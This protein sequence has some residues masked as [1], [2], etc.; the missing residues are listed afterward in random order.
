MRLREILGIKIGDIITVVGAGGKTT[1]MFT[2]G[3]ELRKDNKVLITTTTRIYMPE[4]HQFDFVEINPNGF[5][6]EVSKKG[7]YIYGESLDDENKIKGLKLE[8]LEKQ[9]HKFD[10]VLIEGD[11]SK[12]KP[13]KGWRENEPVISI[14]TTKTI[15][16]LSIEVI[17]K[18]INE[19]NVHR[20]DRFLDI[21]NSN[22][23][24]I[25]NL[26]KVISLIFHEKGLFKDSKGEKILFINKVE[27][28]T[29]KLIAEKLKEKIREV[30]NGYLNRIIYGSLRGNNYD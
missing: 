27:S 20:V 22:M 12:K 8:C 10:Y 7:I 16:V 28:H 30:S 19:E 2:L 3:E 23:N 18:E 5:S 17:G 24:D 11:G 29:D 14:K 9:L 4:T 26:D 21:T 15:G 6:K 25:I 1:L 13:I